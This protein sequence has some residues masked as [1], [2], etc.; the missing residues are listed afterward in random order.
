MEWFLPL[1]KGKFIS[2]NSAIY[3]SPKFNIEHSLFPRA[4]DAK[5]V[6]I[7]SVCLSLLKSVNKFNILIKFIG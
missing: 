7:L 1:K 5:Y 3:N 4:F 6:C 2:M